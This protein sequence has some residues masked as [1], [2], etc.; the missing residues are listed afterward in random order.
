MQISEQ[1]LSMTNGGF[2]FYLFVYYKYGYNLNNKLTGLPNLFY[3]DRKY[4]VS[5]N[6]KNEEYLFNDFGDSRYSGNVFTFAGFYYG[7]NPK[8]EFIEIVKRMSADLNLNINLD[9]KVRQVLR[10]L[11]L[12]NDHEYLKFWLKY[13][14]TQEILDQ[15]R[16]KIISSFEMVNK[17]NKIITISAKYNKPIYGFVIDDDTVKMYQPY[18]L[19]F[20]W[21]WFGKKPNNWIFGYD[22]LDK[23]GEVVILTAGEK[24]VMT[25]RSLG[26]NAIALNSETAT[27]IDSALLADLK[28]RFKTIAVLYDLD[29]TGIKNSKSLSE[30][31][32]LKRIVLNKKYYESGYGKD[33]S[34]LIAYTTNNPNN[35]EISIGILVDEIYKN[36]K[37]P[38][39]QQALFPKYIFDDLPEILK[40]IT[41]LYKLPVEKEIAL[42]GALSIISGCLPNYCG[43]YNGNYIY[44]NLMIYVVGPAASGK[45]ILNDSRVLG[46]KINEYLTT[47]S[48]N[49]ELKRLFIAGDSSSAGLVLLLNANQGKG[50]IFET[51]GDTISKLFKT[52]FGDFSD[53]LRKIFQHEPILSFRKKDKES[54]EILKPQVSV[55]ISGTPAQYFKFIPDAENGL[56]SRFIIYIINSISEFKNVF[57]E[58]HPIRENYL[59]YS[60]QIFELWNKLNSLDKPI[61]FQFTKIQQN[62]FFEYISNEQ[63]Q[64]INDF[65]EEANA[66]VIRFGIIGFRIAMILT[67]LRNLNNDDT[68]L[69]CN[70][71]DFNTMMII[72]DNLIINSYHILENYPQSE[73]KLFRINNDEKMTFLSRINKDFSRSEAIALGQELKISKATIGRL[74]KDTNLFEKINYGN[75]RKKGKI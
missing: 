32:R 73:N 69:E 43:L 24:D 59:I 71:L 45:G 31:Y 28:T 33:I 37:S 15:Y 47:N 7:L 29:E 36:I 22:Q 5:I 65:G 74:L 72:M 64:S 62:R 9:K 56:F 63:M 11:K 40:Q 12:S 35:T 6:I 48:D 16:V 2:D 1:L 68:E 50:I 60:Q 70:D 57:E 13:G 66:I 67:I 34:D 23:K 17:Q 46:E 8:T 20:K 54:T 51:E 38:Y 58:Q 75:Y 44:P 49:K 55:V 18:S 30:N 4:S 27:I 3:N 10:K 53:S 21:R 25:L 39:H 42:L 26:F 14:I 61:H 19:E 41:N 52:E